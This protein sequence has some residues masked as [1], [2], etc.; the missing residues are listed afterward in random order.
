MKNPGETDAV[1][2][3]RSFK[4]LH[5][6]SF[7]QE[8]LYEDLDPP[9]RLLPGADTPSR[10][11]EKFPTK[12][13]TWQKEPIQNQRPD[14]KAAIRSSSFKMNKLG[15]GQARRAVELA[16]GTMVARL[17]DLD[18]FAY[19]NPNDVRIADCGEGVQVLLTGVLPK[20]R[21]LLES[22]YGFLLLKNGIPIGYGTGAGLFSSCE[23]AF[24]LFPAFRGGE[25]ALIYSLVLAI[26]RRL[27]DAD[28]FM[29]DPYQLGQDNEEALHSGAWWFYANLGFMPLEPAALRLAR[30]EMSRRRKRAGYRSSIS[31]LE[32]LSQY[33]VF[34]ELRRKRRGVLGTLNLA[35]VGLAVT[36]LMARRFGSD[37]K[38]G[39]RQCAMEVAHLLKAGSLNNTTA[40]EREAWERWSPLVLALGSVHSWPRKDQ[41]ALVEV[42]RA[43]GGHHESNFVPLFDGHQRLRKGIQRM[44][45]SG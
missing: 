37:R 8:K 43:K 40:D 13:I 25:T 38:G 17:R 27:F 45:E 36:D 9:L 6:D 34:L 20:R 32:R 21:L 7:L 35:A 12:R 10:S 23:V 5:A 33:P 41:R 18:A 31:A 24:N 22:L 16:R 4:A 28:T 42:I 39:T 2:L 15:T 1:F 30:T 14:L 44:A 19:A 26:F 3:I 29:V 11:T